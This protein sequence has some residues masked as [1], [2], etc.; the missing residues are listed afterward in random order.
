MQYIYRVYLVVYCIPAVAPLAVQI[1]LVT[2]T[3]DFLSKV[4]KCRVFD[5]TFKFLTSLGSLEMHEDTPG[6][7]VDKNDN[8]Y[9]YG[10]D[11]CIH[12]Y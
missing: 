12:V 9:V 6:M 8:L 7:V 1:I 2:V 5:S 3:V 10:I 11:K 4:F